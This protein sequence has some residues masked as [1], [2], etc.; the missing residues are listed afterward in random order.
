MASTFERV[1]TRTYPPKKKG[2]QVLGKKYPWNT[3]IKGWHPTPNLTPSYNFNL[4]FV[5]AEAIGDETHPGPPYRSGGPVKILKA[6]RMTPYG[7]Q[8]V[9]TYLQMEGENPQFW[10]KYVGG[11]APPAE[12]DFGT[13]IEMSNPVNLLNLSSTHFPDIDAY[14]SQAWSK[15]RPKL[16]QASAFVFVAELRDLPRMLKNIKS[17]AKAFYHEWWDVKARTHVLKGDFDNN[18]VFM[19]PNEAADYFLE[20]QFG[21]APFVD[22]IRKILATYHNAKATLA[23]LSEQNGQ[24]QRRKATLVGLPVVDSSL[25]RDGKPRIRYEP[26]IEDIRVNSGVGQ[27]Q[28][29]TLNNAF[30]T[31]LPTWEI[32]RVISTKVS[33]TG[34][35]Q[36]Y[37][38]E[39][40]L[41]RSEYH[42]VLAQLQRNLTLYGARI[43]PSNVY[44]ATPWTW[45][46][47]WFTNISDHVDRMTDV[48]QD[49]IVAEY[50][51]LNIRKETKWR[52]IQTLPFRQTGR[53]NL[54][55]E[56]KL[57]TNERKGANSPYGFSLSWE[58]LTPRQLA[59]L[60]ALGITKG[61]KPA[62][63][64]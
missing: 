11:F 25:G 2:S 38:P 1:R 29:P 41:A 26:I 6:E 53:I 21:W 24:S 19:R 12:A 55:W 14:G 36:F 62:G 9:N 47:D 52:F 40:D 61:R 23:R 15:T 4:P 49:S 54:V 3:G 20:H 44:R 39:F 60:G 7:I 31:E 45:L 28:T 48:Y 18:E 43:S 10:E 64:L 13:T 32:R 63:G 46:V 56:R 51:Y 42:S 59:I 58:N 33:A 50:L 27:L 16:Q 35:F 34:K 8:G 17:R 57:R 30:Y 22:D 5:E 37:R